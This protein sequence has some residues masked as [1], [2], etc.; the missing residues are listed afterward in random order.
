MNVH[1]LLWLPT[2]FLDWL[3]LSTLCLSNSFNKFQKEKFRLK[4]TLKFA[5]KKH[6]FT[7]FVIPKLEALRVLMSYMK[8]V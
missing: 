7:L 1:K 3:K 5:K 4:V 8:I 2:S 6:E